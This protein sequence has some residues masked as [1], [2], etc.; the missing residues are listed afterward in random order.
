MMFSTPTEK[1]TTSFSP[2]SFK[3]KQ[4]SFSRITA[5]AGSSNNWLLPAFLLFFLLPLAPLMAEEGGVE[6]VTSVVS[7]EK[8]E[9]PAAAC[10]VD[11]SL[12]DR[13]T[14]YRALNDQQA[15]ASFHGQPGQLL[16]EGDLE[17][18]PQIANRPNNNS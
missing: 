3:Q 10:C 4:Q 14:L 13:E 15:N 18:G 2:F 11:H 8:E 12:N 9:A 7:F 5:I 17:D 1:G 6:T 16:I